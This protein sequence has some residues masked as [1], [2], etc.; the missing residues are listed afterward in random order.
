MGKR[1]RDKLPELWTRVFNVGSTDI[2][3]IPTHP[4]GA[5]ILLAA[6]L[7]EAATKRKK[8]AFWSSY[9]D[10]KQWLR[11]HPRKKRSNS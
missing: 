10:P 3:K 2:D 1:H 7:D 5:D 9:F 4:I 6:A 11:D 8:E